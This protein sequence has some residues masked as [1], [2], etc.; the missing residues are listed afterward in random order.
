MFDAV[1]SSHI[2][3]IGF[4]ITM[5]VNLNVGETKGSRNTLTMN[6]IN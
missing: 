4:Q 3:H 1:C 6:K 2:N 5:G